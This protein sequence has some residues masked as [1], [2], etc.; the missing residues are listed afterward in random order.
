MAKVYGIILTK[1][2]YIICLAIIC[3]NSFQGFDENGFQISVLCGG[4][5]RRGKAMSGDMDFVFT[6][7]DGHRFVNMNPL[8]KVLS[9]LSF[10]NAES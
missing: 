2:N 9:G 10:F 8:S 3:L 5:Y 4:S 7:P 6:H 1:V